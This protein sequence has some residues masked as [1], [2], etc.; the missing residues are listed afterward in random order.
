MH[1]LLFLCDPCGSIELNWPCYCC[2]TC[3]LVVACPLMAVV[4]V[5]FQ[6]FITGLR[7]QASGF[8][9][10]HALG[11]GQHDLHF[12][13]QLY[14]K[15]NFLFS[16]CTWVSVCVTL[17][18]F[19]YSYQLIVKTE[20]TQ[21]TLWMSLMANCWNTRR[22]TTA[23][24]VGHTHFKSITIF[25]FGLTLILIYAWLL[26]KIYVL[27][28]FC[29]L[30]LLALTALWGRLPFL[31][32]C[33]LWTSPVVQKTI[34]FRSLAFMLKRRLTSFRFCNHISRLN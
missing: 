28:W 5:L 10:A 30:G 20:Q 4:R 25:L 19:C 24:P 13:F 14:C 8:N 32:A 22:V 7:T 2:R 34:K 3:S 12:N 1:F 29:S 33:E 15:F 16:I 26:E 27:P 18:R 31:V 6:C 23:I 21:D 9:M 11:Q 17:N